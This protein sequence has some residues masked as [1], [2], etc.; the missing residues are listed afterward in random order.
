MRNKPPPKTMISD[1]AVRLIIYIY[2]YIHIFPAKSVGVRF[3]VFSFQDDVFFI[4][5]T[6]GNSQ[7][8]TVDGQGGGLQKN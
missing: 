4:F 6:A 1:N 2:I 8:S 3:F 5:I 7:R